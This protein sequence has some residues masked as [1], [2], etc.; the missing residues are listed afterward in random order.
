MFGMPLNYHFIITVAIR[1]QVSGRRKTAL[2][3]IYYRRRA[4][5]PLGL[6]AGLTS[7]DLHAIRTVPPFSA[8]TTSTALAPIYAALVDYA[9]QMTRNISVPE[10]TFSR[11]KE[12]LEGD[13]RKI[14]EA[15]ATVAG[16]NF[17]TRVL[18]ALNVAGLGE[19]E[20]PVPELN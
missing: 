1:W 7:S 10:P 11:L 2:I 19:V 6:A 12:L 15:T 9:D 13:D 8:S 14:V 16:Y 20:V 5:V 18:R 3:R 4:H 17:S